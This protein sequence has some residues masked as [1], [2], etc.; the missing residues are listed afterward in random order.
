MNVHWSSWETT[1]CVTLMMRFGILGSAFAY[2]VSGE[3]HNIPGDVVYCIGFGLFIGSALYCIVRH[4]EEQVVVTSFMMG[5]AVIVYLGG[6]LGIVRLRNPEYVL[7]FSSLLVGICLII[8]TVGVV[9]SVALLQL[10]SNVSA[11]KSRHVKLVVARWLF[12]IGT[13]LNSFGI[14][15]YSIEYRAENVII[16]QSVSIALELIS[17]ALIRHCMYVS[18]T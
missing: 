16:L 2:C 9:G 13:I 5:S 8:G 3:E 4:K 6:V 17:I 11:N 14:G 18:G 1:Y 15:A 10:E 7:I 12:L